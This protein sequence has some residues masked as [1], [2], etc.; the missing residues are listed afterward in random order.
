[1]THDN[2]GGPPNNRTPQICLIVPSGP[3]P[4]LWGDMLP[5]ILDRVPIACVRL[6]VAGWGPACIARTAD[7]VRQTAH[8]RDV[9]V[10]IDGPGALAGRFGLDGVHLGADAGA[11]GKAR[12]M[13][14]EDAIV[15]A[16]CA[17][18]RHDGMVAGEAGADYVAFGPTRAVVDPGGAGSGAGHAAHDL[19]AWW[20]EMIEIPVMAEGGLSQHVIETLAPVTDF[21]AIG[22]EIWGA[23]DPLTALVG[24]LAPLAPLR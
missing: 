19:F 9:A 13:L 7:A 14:G 15:G 22:P 21:F 24:L 8:A 11:V 16:F 1:M 2:S 5:R 18:S 4:R 3:D 10:V 17:A 20:A 12:R 6:S 23:E